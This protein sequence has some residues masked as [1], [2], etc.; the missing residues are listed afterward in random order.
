MKRND[1]PK[2]WHEDVALLPPPS[3][4]R[5]A[6]AIGAQYIKFPGNVKRDHT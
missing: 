6:S 3:H 1:A 5:Q 4:G 2:I